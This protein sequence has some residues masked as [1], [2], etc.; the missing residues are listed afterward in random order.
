MSNSN[1]SAQNQES[2]RTEETS[3]QEAKQAGEPPLHQQLEK[4]P[5]PEEAS[6]QPAKQTGEEQQ[7]G[8]DQ[9]AGGEV[10][11][12]AA[13]ATAT[14]VNEISGESV[15]SLVPRSLQ[16]GEEVNSKVKVSEVPEFPQRS[17]VR[18]T[19]PNEGVE[20]AVGKGEL[21]GAEPITFSQMFQQRV[22]EF[23]D[24]PALKWKEKVGEGEESQL[25][26]RTATYTD[27]Y[28]SCIDAAK[29]FLK[30]LCS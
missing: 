2:T 26:W 4:Q 17:K 14:V 23:P 13:A 5:E 18:S 7:A 6:D 21:E 20:L 29:S 28:K 9:K 8:D 10:Q 30:V 27:Y 11:P 1:C 25:V 16:A 24:T 19:I 12:A 3:K 22:K 15:S